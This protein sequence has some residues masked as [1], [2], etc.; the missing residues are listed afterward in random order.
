[1]SQFQFQS[2]NS[3][4]KSGVVLDVRSPSEIQ[5]DGKMNGC[6]NIPLPEVNSAFQMDACK[7]KVKYGFEM[8]SK[9]ND[10]IISCR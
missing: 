4:S 5:E 8:P 7:F 3:S 2:F 9:K 10:L 1:M 6:N